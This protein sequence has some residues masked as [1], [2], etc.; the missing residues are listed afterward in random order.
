MI[1]KY[2]PTREQVKQLLRTIEQRTKRNKPKEQSHEPNHFNGKNIVVV[3]FDL[4]Y[5]II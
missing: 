4:F 3:G 5:H 2:Q 1:N